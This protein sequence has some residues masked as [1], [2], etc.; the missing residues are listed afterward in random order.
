MMY[1]GDQCLELNRKRNIEAHQQDRLTKAIMCDTQPAA[2]VTEMLFQHELYWN[3]PTAQQAGGAKCRKWRL[4]VDWPTQEPRLSR[5]D[6]PTPEGIWQLLRLLPNKT[7]WFHGDSITT[8]LCEASFCSLMR[9]GLLEQQPPLCTVANRHPRM[10]PCE[11]LRAL[12]LAT[13]PRMQVRAAVL[14]NGARLMC[15][16]VGVFEPDNI[17]RLLPHADLAMFNYGLHY[18]REETFRTAMA[19]LFSELEQWSAS[20]TK[21]GLYREQSA[22]HFKGGAW[23]PGADRPPPGAPCTCEALDARGA[24]DNIERVLDN[25]NILF[26]EVPPQLPRRRLHCHHHRRRRGLNTP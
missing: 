5:Q 8:Q 13:Q 4:D 25:Q 22:Q 3:E 2:C 7:V 23:R 6:T 9:E 19:G 26:N 14:P 15:S 1:T 11:D 20:G 24:R 18:H 16:A 12:E 21:I 17:R 10:P